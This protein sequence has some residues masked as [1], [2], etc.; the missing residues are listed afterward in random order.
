[1]KFAA[2]MNK[3]IKIFGYTFIRYNLIII[4]VWVL[5]ALTTLVQVILAVI[6]GVFL[7]VCLQI[8]LMSLQIGAATFF[9][10]MNKLELDT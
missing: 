10:L 9:A 2:V 8:F 1:M 3:R 7:T 6:A 4:A 5:A